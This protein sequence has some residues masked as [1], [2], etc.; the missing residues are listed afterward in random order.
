MVGGRNRNFMLEIKRSI[1]EFA[2]DIFPFSVSFLSL[3]KI[4]EHKISY[5]K[6]LAFNFQIPNVAFFA[7]GW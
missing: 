6:S 2:A 1:I 4:N 3:Y 5:T 7:S